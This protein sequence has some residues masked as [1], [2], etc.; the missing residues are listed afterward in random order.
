MGRSIC[1]WSTLLYCHLFW[2]NLKHSDHSWE[3]V[4]HTCTHGG[5]KSNNLTKLNYSTHL[6][7]LYGAHSSLLSVGA[8]KATN[9]F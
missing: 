7:R 5:A 9:M 8:F 6:C 4:M 1:M 2:E 3:A